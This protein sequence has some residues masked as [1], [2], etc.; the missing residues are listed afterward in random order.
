MAIPVPIFE[1][2]MLAKNFTGDT[3]SGVFIAN[4]PDSKP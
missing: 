3:D 1:T 2:K 4:T